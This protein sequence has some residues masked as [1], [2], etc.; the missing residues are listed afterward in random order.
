MRPNHGSGTVP[1]TLNWVRHGMPLV[2]SSQWLTPAMLTRKFGFDAAPPQVFEI[3]RSV[4]EPPKMRMPCGSRAFTLNSNALYP[5]RRFGSLVI[6]FCTARDTAALIG[7]YIVIG[8][9]SIGLKMVT[10][11]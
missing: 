2:N 4:A 9:P 1:A 8:E 10:G 11:R 6:T 7:S 3:V 5:W